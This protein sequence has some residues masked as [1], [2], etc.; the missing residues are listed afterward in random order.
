[1]A[2]TVVNRKGR[3]RW[4]DIVPFCEGRSCKDL[5]V[6]WEHTLNPNFKRGTWSQD[7]LRDLARAV[8]V[9]DDPQDCA[10]I[11]RSLST[12]RTSRQVLT[13]LLYGKQVGRKSTPE[14]DTLLGDA[15][16]RRGRKWVAVSR[17]L[18]SRENKQCYERWSDQLD[19]NIRRGPWTP[20]EDGRLLAAH[21]SAK[22]AH[23][24]IVSVEVRTRSKRQC[25]YRWMRLQARAD[26]G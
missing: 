9:T 13:R 17:E 4:T 19:P 24:S 6:R 15:V 10:G 12:R 3:P 23:W 7:E 20:E 16:A 5:L 26:L 8:A 14:E 2:R 22:A 25:R 11:A 21:A 1:M 18:P